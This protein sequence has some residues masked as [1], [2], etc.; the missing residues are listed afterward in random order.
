MDE[1][2]TKLDLAKA[3]IDM[4]DEGAAKLIVEEVLENG[5]E[6]QQETAKTLLEELH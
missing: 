3:Y 6:Q 1:F 2:E 4:G 5:N